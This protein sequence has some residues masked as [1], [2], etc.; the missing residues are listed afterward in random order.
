MPSLKKNTQ[1]KSEIRVSK[2]G[3]VN[4]NLREVSAMLDLVKNES[5][6]VDSRF[7]EPACGDGI[8][9]LEVLNRKLS[10]FIK[11]YSKSKNDFEKNLFISI[12]SIYGID[13]LND[14]VLDCRNKI[15]ENSFN[16]YK[17]YF[18][19]DIDLKFLN[20]LKHVIKKNIIH[21]DALD[22]TLVDSNKSPI[23]FTE[24]SFIDDTH[25]KRR[26]FKFNDLIAYQHPQENDL[27]SDLG[28]HAFIPPVIKEY[29]PIFYK[30]LDV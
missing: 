13:I 18:D 19:T 2:F 23:I 20:S 15:Y 25:V 1:I 5:F 7:L 21:G 4:T 29:K 12:S 16:I 22:L 10:S 30:N 28:E 26:E 14:N 27:F 11:K 9:I 3:E 17:K 8:F 6:R 24:W